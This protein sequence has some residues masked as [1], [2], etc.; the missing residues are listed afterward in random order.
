M[1]QPCW[2]DVWLLKY[3]YFFFNIFMSDYPKF[4]WT[5]QPTNWV[6][7][8]ATQDFSLAA[9][10]HD[11]VEAQQWIADPRPK[12]GS[13]EISESGGPENSISR[14][15]RPNSDI[16]SQNDHFGLVYDIIYQFPGRR[17]SHVTRSSSPAAC[18][19][20][21]FREWSIV[22]IWLQIRVQVWN[23]C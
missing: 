19:L 7:G 15:R 12:L 3:A 16:Y 1:M 8:W 4:V 18:T 22:S 13:A 23:P 9:A 6:V 14:W 17:S 21:N 2:L 10:M 5:T 20:A 11:K